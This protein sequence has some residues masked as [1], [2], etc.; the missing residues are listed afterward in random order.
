MTQAT[1]H[2]PESDTVFS[3]DSLKRRL[4]PDSHPQLH[5]KERHRMQPDRDVARNKSA[6]SE[7]KKWERSET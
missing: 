7:F 6:A 4:N 1:Y 5:D 3:V 2:C